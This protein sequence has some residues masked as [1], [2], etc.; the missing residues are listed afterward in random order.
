MRQDVLAAINIC[1]KFIK[2]LFDTD[3]YSSPNE[4]K[5]T[6]IDHY[7]SYMNELFKWY[8]CFSK[9]ILEKM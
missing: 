5:V 4:T 8:S 9:D 7:D 6:S 1:E 3:S 2:L